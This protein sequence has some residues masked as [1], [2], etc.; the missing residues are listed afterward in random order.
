MAKITA[1][2]GPDK[3]EIEFLEDGSFKITTDKISAANHVGADNLIKLLIAE[4]GGEATKEAH[5]GHRAHTH[6]HN[7]IEHT[8]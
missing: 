6:S 8:H 1:T 3:L 7:G 4:A 5:K 2:K